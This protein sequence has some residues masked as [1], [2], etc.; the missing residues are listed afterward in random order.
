[1][2]WGTTFLAIRIS[3]ESLPPLAMA[4]I[5]HAIAGL[6]IALVVTSRGIELPSRESWST[7]ALLGTLMIGVGNGGVVWAEQYVPSGLAAVMVSVIPFWMVAVEALMPDGERIRLPQLIGLA[8]G[9]GGILLLTGLNLGAEDAGGRRF[10][11]GVISLQLSC[12]GWAIGS[13]YAKRHARHEN[14]FA[15]TSLQMIFG[16]AALMLAGTTLG[17]WAAIH[18]TLRSGLAIVYLIV[19]GSLIGYASYTYALKY[20]PVSTVSLYAYVD[21]VIAVILGA[22]VLNEPF[23][24]RMAAAIAVIFTAMLLVRRSADTSRNS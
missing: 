17:E 23:R 12:C 6:I 1:V 14:V 11:H 16:G 21:P 15:A 7:H 20:L 9:F 8:L 4:G 13:S 22:V 5:R 19:F 24:P 2:C 10:L 18:M 3:L